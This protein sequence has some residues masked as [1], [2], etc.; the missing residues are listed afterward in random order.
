MKQG[1]WSEFLQEPEKD[2]NWDK[3]APQSVLKPNWR[4]FLFIIHKFISCEGRYGLV[5]LYH[6]R[7]IL[8]FKVGKEINLPF[9]L[10][11]SLKK[12]AQGI[13]RNP[14]NIQRS[15]YHHGFIRII[16]EEELKKTND[17]WEQFCLV[18]TLQKFMKI[19]F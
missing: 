14:R 12:M 10:W 1:I 4:N 7:T 19:M 2:I 9:Y 6:I 8:H 13:Q 15:L 3:G 5:F 16:V 17:S 11:S 18:I